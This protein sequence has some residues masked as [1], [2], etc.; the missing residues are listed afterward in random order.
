MTSRHNIVAPL[1]FTL[2]WM[3]FASEKLE[4]VIRKIV[5]EISGVANGQQAAAQLAAPQREHFTRNCAPR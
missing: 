2:F 1:I 3:S 4:K 5:D